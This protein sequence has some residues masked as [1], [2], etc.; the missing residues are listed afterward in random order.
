MLFALSYMAAGAA[1]YGPAGP[2]SPALSRGGV[3]RLEAREP[4][5]IRAAALLVLRR[6]RLVALGVD[7]AHDDGVAHFDARL[8]AG[9]LRVEAREHHRTSAA[10][11][12][13]ALGALAEALEASYQKA[14]TTS[15]KTPRRIGQL[16]LMGDVRSPLPRQCSLS[17][18]HERTAANGSGASKQRVRTSQAGIPLRRQ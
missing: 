18:K 8:E 10:A 12:V 9:T 16:E 15:A 3:S 4:L 13:D 14:A 7:D 1:Y 6:E 5:G 2:P 17:A 11:C